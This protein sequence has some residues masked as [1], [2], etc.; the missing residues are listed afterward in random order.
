M[1]KKSGEQRG[2][3]GRK[4]VTF[5]NYYCPHPAVSLK[6]LLSDA[7][8]VKYVQYGNWK[9]LVSFFVGALFY[10]IS[11][12]LWLPPPTRMIL[13][14]SKDFSDF[15]AH[16]STYY[17]FYSPSL[18]PALLQ[19]VPRGNA[20]ERSGGAGKWNFVS[21][22]FVCQRQLKWAT[23]TTDHSSWQIGRMLERRGGGGWIFGWAKKCFV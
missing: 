7:Y 12:C 22:V 23:K 4:C 19:V 3:A 5:Q 15:L 1:K 6:K 10:V 16:Y 11:Y 17:V 8:R 13:E 9:K 18:P 2:E 21:R 20:G 14:E